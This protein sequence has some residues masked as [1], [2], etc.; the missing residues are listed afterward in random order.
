MP[1]ESPAYK[2]EKLQSVYVEIEKGL[3]NYLGIKAGKKIRP[4]DKLVD[5]LGIDS[6]DMLEIVMA[7]EEKYGL[8]I[9]DADIGKMQTVD[10]V[11]RYV[12]KDRA[13]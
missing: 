2:D 8:S 3:R 13:A 1:D 5:D 9:P 12:S 10:D 4:D 7:F 6:L 11:V